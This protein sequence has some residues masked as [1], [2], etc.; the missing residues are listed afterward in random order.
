VHGPVQPEGPEQV[1][2]I[3]AGGV[4]G[5]EEVGRITGDPRQREYHQSQ[6][7]EDDEAL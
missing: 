6:D 3:V 2:A 1:L 4:L 5:Q 7:D